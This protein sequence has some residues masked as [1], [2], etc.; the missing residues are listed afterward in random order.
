VLLA[1]LICLIVISL[2]SAGLLKLVLA[3][4]GRAEAGAR[5]IQAEWLAES[6]LERAVAR[7]AQNGNYSGETWD[8]ST[9]DL[10][11]S[12][13]G[14]VRIDVEKVEGHASQRLVKIQ[15]DYPRDVT[16][17]ARQSKQTI[18]ELSS[19]PSGERP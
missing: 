3:Q 11:G 5:Q 7:L 16:L 6:G 8:L 15:A 13:P 12:R 2:L 19:E 18:V 9:D 1:V 10:G 14:R 4:R 17:R